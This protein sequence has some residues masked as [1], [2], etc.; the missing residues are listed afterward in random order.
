MKK[1]VRNKSYAKETTTMELA[2]RSTLD[3]PARQLKHNIPNTAGFKQ[4]EL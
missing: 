2:S 4:L 1:E 3:A